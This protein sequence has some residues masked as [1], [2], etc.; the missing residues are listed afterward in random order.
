MALRK[1]IEVEGNSVIQTSIGNIENG[2]QRLSFSAYVK[3]I[4]INGNKNQVIASVNFKGESQQ[5]NK[6]YAV[7]MSVESG[8]PNFIAQVYAYLK[9]LEEF[10]GAV[11]C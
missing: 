11:D 7:P 5:F 9:T 1:I 4:G 6:N 10:A 3:V 8:S 2:T